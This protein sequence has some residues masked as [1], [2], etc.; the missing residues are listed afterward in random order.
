LH[1]EIKEHSVIGK[2]LL[3]LQ[4]CCFLK[5]H[6]STR[7][8]STS[9]KKDYRFFKLLERNQGGVVVVFVTHA[10]RKDTA[11]ASTCQEF[12]EHPVVVPDKG[13]RFIKTS[14]LKV[15]TS[16]A[17]LTITAPRQQQ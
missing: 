13:V 7:L 2:C 1:G 5:K 9:Y 6:F 14:L 3:P 11:S 16:P 15:H 4:R 8:S 12:H 10:S 17:A